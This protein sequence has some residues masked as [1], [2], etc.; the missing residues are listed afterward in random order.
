MPPASSTL[1]RQTILLIVVVFASVLSLVT[2]GAHRAGATSYVPISGAGS[3]WSQNAL[4]QWR[5]N[6]VQFGMQVN[7]QGTGSSDGRNQFKNGTVDFAVSEIPYGLT[8]QG[9]TDPPPQRK[10]AYI[11]I[12][13]GGTSLMYNLR[14]N[15]QRV[16]N[17]RLSGKV[18]AGIF[19]GTIT[20]WSDPAIAAD[21]PGL[22]LPARTVVPVVRSDGSGTTAQFTTWL[23]KQYPDLWNAYC[24][25]VGVPAPCGQTSEY[26]VVPGSSFTAQSG[27]LGTAGYVAQSQS[28]GAITYVEYSYALNAGFPV[29]K[30]LNAGGYYTEPTPDNVAVSLTQA[31]IDSDP[32]SVSYLTQDLSGVYSYTDAR[33]YP[34]SSYSYMI[35]PTAVEN[36]FSTSKGQTL[37]AFVYYFLCEGQKQAPRLGYSPLPINLVQ[38]G[39]DQIRKVPGV[40][41]QN[42]NVAGCA[43]PNFSSDGTPTLAKTAPQP[44]ACDKQGTTQCAT[45]TGGNKADT[46]V[47]SSPAAAGGTSA[48]AGGGAA[49]GGTPAN[50]N[51]GAAGGGS[52]LGTGGGLTQS[53]NTAAAGAGPQQTSVDQQ[54]NPQTVVDQSGQNIN[55]QGDAGS[56]AAVPITL[57]SGSGSRQQQILMVLAGVLLLLLVIGPPLLSQAL[58]KK[59]PR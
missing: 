7:Y 6:V 28:E 55:A 27:S 19:T 4:D 15:G 25:K 18:I 8:D 35:I 23:S 38:A 39:F 53:G 48:G 16:T 42:I 54:G 17:L 21:N 36:N 20:N 30:V 59:R 40:E 2:V 47:K 44:P 52:A 13:A 57:S 51:T 26:P 22:T 1:V 24:A 46:A 34:I 33:T 58:G 49:A 14:I 12:V 29:A 3:T 50:R 31:R 56:V 11:P 43:N 5:R 45:G 10:Y 32:S 37:G 9:V 41:V